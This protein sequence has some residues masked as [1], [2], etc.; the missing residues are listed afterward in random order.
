MLLHITMNVQRV[1]YRSKAKDLIQID[2]RKS[3]ANG[4]RAW[5]K[6]QLVIRLDK[7]LAGEQ[8]ANVN[9]M[10][11]GMNGDHLV[12]RLHGNAESIPKSPRAISSVSADSSSSITPPKSMAIATLRS[13]SATATRAPLRQC[14]NRGVSFFGHREHAIDDIRGMFDG[15]GDM[16]L[17]ILISAT[18]IDQHRTFGRTALFNTFV[19]IHPSK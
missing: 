12:A 10:H 13:R 2:S 8:V 1:L 5:R 19:D 18:H 9:R 17:P 15:T 3:G 14:T 11:I 6:N 4:M 16:S 7:F